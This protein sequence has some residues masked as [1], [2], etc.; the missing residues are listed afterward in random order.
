MSVRP[1][2]HPA[3]GESDVGGAAVAVAKN[4]SEVRS[5]PAMP[6]LQL[7]VISA[8]SEKIKL[9][10]RSNFFYH[11]VAIFISLLNDNQRFGPF[12]LKQSY[13]LNVCI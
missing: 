4:L 1:S 10:T 12:S 2:E 7:D 5:S 8:R 6:K 11:F 3:E 13:I 9:R